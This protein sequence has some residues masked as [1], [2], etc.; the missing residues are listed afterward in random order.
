MRRL[1]DLQR[2]KQREQVFVRLAQALP[3][4]VIIR[5]SK[6]APLHVPND[7]VNYPLRRRQ[8]SANLKFDS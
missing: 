7:Y 6:S 3:K 1:W 8:R 2:Y 5:N 4:I